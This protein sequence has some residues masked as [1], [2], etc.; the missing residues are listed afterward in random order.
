MAIKFQKD[1][2]IDENGRCVLLRGVNIGANSK[3]PANPLSNSFIKIDFADH[4]EVSYV[5][6]PIPLEE[7]DEHFQRLKSWGF[8]CI[9][10]LISWEG[11]EHAGPGQYDEEYLEYIRQF[12]EKAGNYGIYILIDPHQDVWARMAGGDGAPGWTFEKVGI[13]FTKF[14][15]RGSC[16]CHAISI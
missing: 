9:R 10:L 5:G 1:Q 3:F 8:N 4:R 2:F 14:D 12:C 6:A 16:L 13:D 11:I 15:A 7:A